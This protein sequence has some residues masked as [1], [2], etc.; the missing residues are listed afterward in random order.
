[1]THTQPLKERVIKHGTSWY[2]WFQIHGNLQPRSI[3][4]HQVA[5]ALS[6]TQQSS[7]SEK[8]FQRPSECFT[9]HVPTVTI[10]DGLLGQWR[11]VSTSLMPS[12]I[13]RIAAS[14]VHSTSSTRHDFVTALI[15]IWYKALI[16]LY[17]NVLYF[18]IIPGWNMIVSQVLWS[19]RRLIFGADQIISLVSFQKRGESM[20]DLVCR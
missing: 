1:M 18:E 15:H 16:L 20:A 14:S 3:D 2:T 5:S 11:N 19:Y 9:M 7:I 8:K 6:P 4:S 12:E 17:H 13:L 10:E